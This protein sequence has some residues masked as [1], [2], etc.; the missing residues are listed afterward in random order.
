[1]NFS[2]FPAF[3]TMPEESK[4]EQLLGLLIAGLQDGNAAAQSAPTFS[5]NQ[6]LYYA[7]VVKAA[8][9]ALSRSGD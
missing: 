9:K 4:R 3:V 2:P 5:N 7:A 6:A 8:G 1:M